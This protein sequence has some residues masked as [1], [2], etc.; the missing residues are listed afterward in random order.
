MTE[1][2]LRRAFRQQESEAK[3]GFQFTDPMKPLTG[4]EAAGLW[5]FAVTNVL[6]LGGCIGAALYVAVGTILDA[7]GVI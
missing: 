2:E 3:K 4:I 7:L 5:V 1:Q 6:F